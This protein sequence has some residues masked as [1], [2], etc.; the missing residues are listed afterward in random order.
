MRLRITFS[1]TA[2]MRFTSHLDLHRAWERT[3]R[4]AG[5]PL[6]YSQGF[7]PHPRINLASA[8]LLGITGEGEVVELWLEQP[9]ELVEIQAALE[10][11]TP[12][13]IVIH[14]L[15][16]V[17]PHSPTLQTTLVA[18]EYCLTFDS[19][20]EDLPSRVQAVLNSGSLPRQRR[21]KLYDLR[22]L[23]LDL[24]LLANDQSGNSMLMVRLAAKEGE[25]GRPEELV[26]QLG[27]PLSSVRIHRVR[28]LFQETPIT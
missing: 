18:S 10:K 9:L 6:A 21:G 15:E 7:N 5:L 25:T 23:I 14:R 12:P 27:L 17:A 1:K 2:E 26:D 20:I 19:R 22:P 24:S 4:R 13:G 28:L 8:L 3:L 16:Q 11:A